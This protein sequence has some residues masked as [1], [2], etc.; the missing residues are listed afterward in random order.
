MCIRDSTRTAVLSDGLSL[1]SADR[2]EV[3]TKMAPLENVK[4][5]EVVKGASSVVY[6]SSALN[7]VVNVITEWPSQNEPKTEL[8]TNV[9]IY[10]SPKDPRQRWWGSAPPFFGSVNVNHQDVYK[11]QVLTP[12]TSHL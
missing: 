10:D 4:Q 7:G 2:G 9:G 5:V 6:G 11:R 12:R 1:S 8:E 3:Q